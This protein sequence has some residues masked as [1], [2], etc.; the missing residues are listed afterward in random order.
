MEYRPYYFAREWVHLGHQVQI[1]AASYSHYRAKQPQVGKLTRLDE[2]IDGILY[3][4]FK[5][6]TYSGNGIGRVFN[7]TSFIGRLFREGRHIA[8]MLKPDIVIASS[9]YPMDIWPAHHIASIINAKLVYEVHDLW[10]LSPIELGDMSKLHPFIML[11]QAAENYAYHYADAVVSI[12]PRVRDY[13]I[14][15]E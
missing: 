14:R 2:T 11:V 3:T 13:M 7:I 6:F 10:P 5:T 1:V 4:W 8:R 15:V 12:L 9:T